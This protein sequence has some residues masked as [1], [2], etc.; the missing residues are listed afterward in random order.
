MTTAK[1]MLRG[2]FAAE[3]REL[4]NDEV[5]VV[6]ST[7]KLA[8]DG[9]ILEPQ[10]VDLSG[11]RKNPIILWQHSPNAPIARAEEVAVDG[12]KITAR[13]RFAPAGVSDDAD[14]IRGLVKSGIVSTMSVG[15]D[16]DWDSAEPIDPKKPRGGQRFKH[17]TLLECSFVSVPADPDAVVTAREHGD[18][19]TAGVLTVNEVRDLEGL[20]ALQ[21]SK[22][23]ITRR[24]VFLPDGLVGS[25]EE[26][27]S[28]DMYGIAQLACAL[29][30]LGYIQ[31]SEQIEAAFEGDNSE[32]PALLMAALK[33]GCAALIAMTVEEC[34]ELVGDDDADGEVGERFQRARRAVSEQDGIMRRDDGG[35]GGEMTMSAAA[36]ALRAHHATAKSLTREVHRCLRSME[37]CMRAIPGAGDGDE[38]DSQ[39]VQTSAGTATSSGS[40]DGR[41]HK[42]L[43]A[44]DIAQQRRSD[45]VKLRRIP[46]RPQAAA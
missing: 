34:A 19:G 26:T 6:M 30:N 41:A 22:D 1:T 11:Y 28:R 4:D 20:P 40:D 44:E 25:T 24:L 13:I 21:R 37:R 10:G 29:D 15:F 45:D 3:I 43:T 12:E 17:W 32:V 9:H 42:A 35:D 23:I 36:T 33:A 38:N 46:A 8:R 18:G 16:P 5:E 31:Y 14:R 7:G 2:I 27:H 39:Q